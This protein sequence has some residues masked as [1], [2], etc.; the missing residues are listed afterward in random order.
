MVFR[1]Y[2]I[3][4][5][6]FCL[7]T[8]MWEKGQKIQRESSERT[9]FWVTFNVTLWNLK[10]V[11]MNIKFYGTNS[12]LCKSWEGSFYHVRKM[13]KTSISERLTGLPFLPPFFLPSFLP[14]PR[15]Q[16]TGL[17]CKLFSPGC[18]SSN[19]LP[20]PEIIYQTLSGCWTQGEA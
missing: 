19:W 14:Q 20:V 18:Q 12:K 16:V 17:I 10:L 9:I 4:F 13:S 15:H 6:C 7:S 8:Y 3:I 11:F 2:S 5:F 1:R